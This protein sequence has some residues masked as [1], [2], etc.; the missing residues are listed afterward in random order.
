MTQLS[1][2]RLA[3]LREDL[4]A[5]VRS[6]QASGLVDRLVRLASEHTR[7]EMTVWGYRQP[8]GSHRIRWWP[9]S[10][11]L[12][13]HDAAYESRVHEHP[14]RNRYLDTGSPGPHRLSDAMSMTQFKSSGLYR[15]YFRHFGITR[16]AAVYVP[17]GRATHISLGVSRGGR[18]FTGAEM[19]TLAYLRPHIAEAFLRWQRV[20]TIDRLFAT[21]EEALVHLGRG[22][23]V[24]AADGRVEH[25][26]PSAVRWLSVAGGP[27]VRD[28]MPAPAALLALAQRATPGPVILGGPHGRVTLR[29]LARAEHLV[30]LVEVPR[31]AR[32]PAHYRQLGLTRRE[33]EILGWIS[34]GRTNVEL[35]AIL[36]VAPSTVKKHLENIYRKLGV[37]NRMAAVQLASVLAGE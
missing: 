15:E 6:E 23:V 14:V 18:D 34:E 22:L 31:P 10:L 13:Q 5:A 37:E 11:D 28:G 3:H 32:T 35:A 8:D 17:L 27:M 9:E 12:A 16:L 2:A 25:V 4:A 24:V 1:A 30:L 26:T 29:R 36:G 20:E 33:A 7:S 19:E 21:A